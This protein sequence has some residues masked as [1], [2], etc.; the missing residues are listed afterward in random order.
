MEL[1]LTLARYAI[2]TLESFKGSIAEDELDIEMA[3]T[4]EEKALATNTRASKLWRAL[5]IASKSKLNLFDQ[6]DDGNNLEALFQPEGEENR[7]KADFDGAE[8]GGQ[9]AA[10]TEAE[11]N[12]VAEPGLEADYVPESVIK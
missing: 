9:D 7:G 1:G 10:L 8:H 6:I 5:R 4:D 12:A 11:Q 3:Q 2:P